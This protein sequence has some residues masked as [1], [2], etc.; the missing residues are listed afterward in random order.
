MEQ[1]DSCLGAASTITGSE[2]CIV[3]CVCVCVWCA[4]IKWLLRAVSP[5]A[6]SIGCGFGQELADDSSSA[7][8]INEAFSIN[9]PEPLAGSV[10]ATE[11]QR[12]EHSHP[13]HVTAFILDRHGMRRS[14]Q[15]WSIKSPVGLHQCGRNGVLHINHISLYCCSVSFC[16]V[17]GLKESQD[18]S[19]YGL[20]ISYTIYQLQS[21]WCCLVHTMW[22]NVSYI[23]TRVQLLSWLVPDLLKEQF[24]KKTRHVWCL[25]GF[26]F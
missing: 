15:L 23:I 2:W 7:C 17:S 22:L 4:G 1:N 11:R 5:Q 19:R 18:G 26:F 21:H 20:I 13:S 8:I 24:G 25:T 3:L 6:V 12:V 14:E 16:S 9:R 10:E